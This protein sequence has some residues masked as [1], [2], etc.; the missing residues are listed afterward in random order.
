MTA[1]SVAALDAWQP[2]EL[3][4][5][6]NDEMFRYEEPGAKT[7]LH[8]DGML[9]IRIDRFTRSH[10]GVQNFD[11]GKHLL[12]AREP[13]DLPPSAVTRFSLEMAAENIGG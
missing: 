5:G 13:I 1:V 3:P 6:H 4:T 2:L 9:E 10:D 11:N 12:L 8:P 7:T